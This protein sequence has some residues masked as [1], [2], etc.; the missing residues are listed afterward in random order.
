MSFLDNG[1][2]DVKVR[3]VVV[4]SSF[5][6]DAEVKTIVDKYTGMLQNVDTAKFINNSWDI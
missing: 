4:D 2:I 5:P 6:E 3:E 1:H